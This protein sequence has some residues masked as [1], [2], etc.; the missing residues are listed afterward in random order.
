MWPLALEGGKGA[1][2]G[3]GR[4]PPSALAHKLHLMEHDMTRAVHA[5]REEDGSFQ[6]LRHLLTKGLAGPGPARSLQQRQSES[7]VRLIREKDWRDAQEAWRSTLRGQQQHEETQTENYAGR[8]V[9]GPR[10][11][12][13]TRGWWD[14]GQRATCSGA[15]NPLVGRRTQ[16]MRR[17]DRTR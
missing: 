3:R 8:I 17:G 7:F 6:G 14:R 15:V 12:L 16:H 4:H 2:C 5:L 9:P 13:V 1:L 10:R 11:R